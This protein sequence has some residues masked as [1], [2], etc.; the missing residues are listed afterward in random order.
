MSYLKIEIER[1]RESRQ[2]VGEEGGKKR[3]IFLFGSR[4]ANCKSCDSMANRWTSKSK[5]KPNKKREREKRMIKKQ[6]ALDIRMFHLLVRLIQTN[7]KTLRK[8]RKKSF[9]FWQIVASFVRSD[10]NRRFSNWICSFNFG[11][12]CA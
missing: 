8:E 10:A 12:L 9:Y 4:L 7:K 6:L 11:E 2:K 1:E 3:D 5:P